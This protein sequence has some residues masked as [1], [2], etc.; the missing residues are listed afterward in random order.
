VPTATPSHYPM[1]P[2]PSE[3][4]ATKKNARSKIRL[5]PRS[6]DLK[7]VVKP[8]DYVGIDPIIPN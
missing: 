5:E 8:L 7:A 4:L 6:T 3:R 2:E 1:P